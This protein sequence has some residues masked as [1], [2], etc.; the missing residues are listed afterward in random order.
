M[1]PQLMTVLRW[2]LVTAGA[3]AVQKG[4]LSNDQLGA[5]VND[6][7]TVVGLVGSL[8]GLAWGIYHTVQSK[9]AAAASAVLGTP[10]KVSG[11]TMPTVLNAVTSSTAATDVAKVKGAT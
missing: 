10:V 7:I 9:R 1:T 8:G 3:L 5:A 4:W 6:L 11:F 2:V